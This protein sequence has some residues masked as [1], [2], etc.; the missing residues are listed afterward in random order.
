MKAQSGRDKFKKFKKIINLLIK[1]D[2]FLP[3]KVNSFLLQFFRN[4]NGVFGLL[5]RYILVKNLA[6][7]CGDNVSIQP[8]VFLFNLHT[9]SFGNNISIHPMCYIDGA[10]KISIGNDVS[11]AHN[12]S[13]LSTNHTWKEIDVPIKYN[14]E[15]FQEVIIQDDVWI[16]C[17]CRILAGVIIESRTIIAAGAVVNKK[18][19]SK[20]IYAGIPA[21]LIKK[22]NE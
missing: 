16:G 21:K 13:I 22:I 19:E 17:G 8:N 2:S 18:I 10:G 12:S 6:Q 20:S 4:T 5:T 14:P 15:T 1:L 11:I 9:I 3:K 7:S